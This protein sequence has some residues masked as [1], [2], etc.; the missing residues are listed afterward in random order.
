MKVNLVERKR[1]DYQGRILI[2][3]GDFKAQQGEAML[4]DGFLSIK[5]IIYV[6]LC[7][8]YFAS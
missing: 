2:S 4:D 3:Y 1:I 8:F 7:G 6:K 5:D